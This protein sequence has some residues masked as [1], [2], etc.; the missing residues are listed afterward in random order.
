MV[1]PN[2]ETP[3]W[4]YRSSRKQEMYLYLHAQDDFSC[5]PDALLS[6]FGTPAMVMQ[7]NLTPQ[8]T[9]AREDVAKVIANLRNQGFHLQMPPKLQVD[10][11]EGD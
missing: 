11:Y 10:L 8:R 5:V 6:G 9:L 4:V 7:L 1:T 3:C 2:E